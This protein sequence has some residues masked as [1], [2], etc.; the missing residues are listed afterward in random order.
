MELRDY[1]TILARRKW[2]ILTTTAV[3][4]AVALVGT[5]LMTPIYRATSTLRVVTAPQG[6]LDFVSY[7]LNYADRLMNTY[8]KIATSLPMLT[9]LNQKLGLAESP[10]VKVELAPNTQ[11]MFIHV[12]DPDPTLASSAANELAKLLMAYVKSTDSAS[13]RTAQE[14]LGTQLS[15]AEDQVAQARAQYARLVAATPRDPAGIDAAERLLKAKEDTYA[16]LVQLYGRVRATQSLQSTTL[17]VIEPAVPPES[18]SQ[19]RKVVNVSVGLLVGLMGGLGLALLF[20]NLDATLYTTDQIRKVTERT[21][22]GK[23]PVCKAGTRPLMNSKTPG[24]EAFRHVRTSLLNLF[25]DAPFHTLLVTSALPGEG[26]STV[27]MNLAYSLAQNGK[28]V[29]LMDCDL[30]A[31]TVHKMLGLPNKR[32]L[33]DALTKG[34]GV[35]EPIQHSPSMGIWVLTSGP[36]PANPAELLSSRKMGALM[37]QLAETFEV[38]VLDTP[39]LLP[40]SDAAALAP[41]VDAVVLVVGRARVQEKA[42]QNACQILENAHASPIGV[43]VNRAELDGSRYY[44]REN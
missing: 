30:R 3:S 29:L 28:K 41:T 19:P 20:E 36:P 6:S 21:I 12:E 27:A 15:Q 40:V 2:I 34:V 22:L 35:Q 26:K 24:G 18:P 43:I 5:L 4:V 38:I 7:D 14:V 17:S 39:A 23:I 31:P 32:G 42:V 44:Y 11:L 9:Q 16:N 1:F 13:D 33:S 37:K 10:V 8:V 25:R